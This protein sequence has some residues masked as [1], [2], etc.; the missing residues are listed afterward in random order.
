MITRTEIVNE[1]RR[2]QMLPKHFGRSMMLVEGAIYNFARLLCKKYDGGFWQFFELSNG[3][4]YM[5]PD[6]PGQLE[7]SWSDNYYSG[8]MSADA[9]GITVCLF[10]F[11]HLSFQL[12]NTPHGEKV[13]EH[14]LLLRDYAAD[15]KEAGAI[16]AA[17]D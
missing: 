15:H 16:F 10:A 11:S 5:A 9:F 12:D 7:V 8:T 4:F 3:G 1:E 6:L 13:A 17:T 2:L 14:Y